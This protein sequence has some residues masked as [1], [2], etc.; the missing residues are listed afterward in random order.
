M[1]LRK[2][3]PPTCNKAALNPARG[4]KVNRA[5]AAVDE[6]EQD[7]E[8]PKSIT[9]TQHEFDLAPFVWATNDKDCKEF[10]EISDCIEKDT[11]AW[12]TWFQNALDS[13]IKQ[14]IADPQ[15]KGY[16]NDIKKLVADF[17]LSTENEKE[18]KE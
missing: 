10:K 8:W 6:K 16:E 11:K 4:N 14:F 7:F 13:I 15:W 1:S 2:A 3:F 5:A 18:E 9:L 17:G 12:H